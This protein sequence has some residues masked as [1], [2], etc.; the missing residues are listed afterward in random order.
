MRSLNGEAD[1]YQESNLLTRVNYSLVSRITSSGQE[2]ISG[3]IT[4]PVNFHGFDR[5]DVY[6]RF[7]ASGIPEFNFWIRNPHPTSVNPTF[8]IAVAPPAART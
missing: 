8:D 3:S 7:V 1:I 6:Y 4:V 5:P 2:D